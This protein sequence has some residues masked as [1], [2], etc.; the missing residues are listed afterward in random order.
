MK[1]SARVLGREAIVLLRNEIARPTSQVG[2][3]PVSFD[4]KEPRD[5][6]FYENVAVSSD[7]LEMALEDFSGKYILPAMRRLANRVRNIPL[8]IEPM[9]LP[10]GVDD[11]ANDCFDGVGLR[12]IVDMTWPLRGQSGP[13]ARVCRYYDIQTDAMETGPCGVAVLWTAHKAGMAM[14]HLAIPIIDN[15]LKTV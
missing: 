7:S 6:I 10:R 3:A 9:E 8:G 13:W 14:A 15:T 12:T 11:A 5:G 4:M 2:P 1:L